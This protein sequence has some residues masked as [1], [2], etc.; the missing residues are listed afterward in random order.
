MPKLAKVNYHVHRDFRQ[1][2]IVDAQGIKGNIVAPELVEHQVKVQDVRHSLQTP[3]FTN[4]GV[5]FIHSPTKVSHFE[6]GNVCCNQYEA[7]LMQ[8]V[9]HRLGAKDV[10]VF[11]HTIRVDEQ[12]SLRKP[13]KHVHSDFSESGAHTRL[14]TLLGDETAQQWQQGHYAFVNVWRPIKRT[15]I[16][17][18]LG[19]I[20]PASVDESQ[21][22][23]IGLKYPDR[24]GEVMGLV[25]HNRHQWFYMSQMTPDDVV[26]FN[27]YDNQGQATVAHSALDLEDDDLSFTRQSI[28][29]RLLIKLS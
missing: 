8:L 5:E 21:W 4:E 1:Y 3:S 29:S 18:N 22:V 23:N 19:F 2:F 17:S 24:E 15:V 9:K 16:N 11:D 20:V 10:L 12:Q 28:E 26:I 27:V 25:H 13:V 6:T 14:K 7:E